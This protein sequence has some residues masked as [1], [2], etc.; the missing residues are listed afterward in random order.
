MKKACLVAGLSA[1]ILCGCEKT[2]GSGPSTDDPA[3]LCNKIADDHEKMMGELG[4]LLKEKPAPDVLRPK[5]ATLKQKYIQLHVASGKLR[6]AY[7]PKVKKTCDDVLRSAMFKMKRDS[8]K[9]LQQATKE[10]RKQDNDLANE[11]ASFNTLTQYA[12]YELLKGQLPKEAK[13]LGIK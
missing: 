13:R 2:G 1:L 9:V 10:I 6:E 11:L 12:S 4:D 3:V 8:L 7:T 5:L